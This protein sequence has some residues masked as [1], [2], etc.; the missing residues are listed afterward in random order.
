MLYI[1]PDDCIDCEACIYE[2]PVEAIFHEDNVPEA[3][4][5]YIDLNRQ[6]AKVLPIIAEKKART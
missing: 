5:G 3:W 1:E 2:C 4:R 6:M